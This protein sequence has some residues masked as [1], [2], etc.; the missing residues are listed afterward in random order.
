MQLELR[1]SPCEKDFR[2]GRLEPTFQFIIRKFMQQYVRCNLLVCDFIKKQIMII[3]SV[4]KFLKYGYLY[5]LRSFLSGFFY[6]SSKLGCV[7]LVK[8][9]VI[10]LVNLNN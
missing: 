3:S 5:I 6:I 7:T 8:H 1:Y 2:V 10:S 4:G 9:D